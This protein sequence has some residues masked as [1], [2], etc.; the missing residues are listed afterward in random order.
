MTKLSFEDWKNSNEM[1]ATWAPDEM[2][3]IEA[4]K[5]NKSVEEIKDMFLQP[6]YQEYLENDRK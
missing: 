6:V 3:E 5:H 1:E 4:K 2:L